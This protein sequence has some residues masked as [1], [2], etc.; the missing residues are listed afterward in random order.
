MIRQTEE[1]TYLVNGRALVEEVEEALGLG[2]GDAENDTVAGHV[3]MVLGSTASIGDEIELDN[4]F[5]VRVVGIRGHQIT[6]LL[7]TP[8]PDSGENESGS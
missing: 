6:D 2:L 7:F 4:K 3:M 8:F 1:G 5:H